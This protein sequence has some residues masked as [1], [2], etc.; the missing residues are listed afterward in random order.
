[1]GMCQTCYLNDYHKRKV[2]TA[3]KAEEEAVVGIKIDDEDVTSSDGESS[4]PI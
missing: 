4:S 3:L 2:T 1:M